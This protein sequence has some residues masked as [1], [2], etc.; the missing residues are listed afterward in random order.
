LSRTLQRR[1][2][3]AEAAEHLRVAEALGAPLL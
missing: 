1:G 2:V 3:V